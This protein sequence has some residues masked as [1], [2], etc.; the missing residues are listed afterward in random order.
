MPTLIMER[1][2]VLGLF[3]IGGEGR[4]VKALDRRHDRL[5]T[6]KIRPVR[7]GQA[8]AELLSEARILLASL[9]CWAIKLP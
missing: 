3:G 9:Y 4:V 6:L 1:Y 2:E 8:R 7:D 5:V